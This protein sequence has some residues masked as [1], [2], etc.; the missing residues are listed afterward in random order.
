MVGNV[1]GWG[2]G[3]RGGG[4]GGKGFVFTESLCRVVP[5]CWWHCHK[6]GGFTHDCN[7]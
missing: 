5:A 3:G 7:N 2:G 1:F 4:E 6:G